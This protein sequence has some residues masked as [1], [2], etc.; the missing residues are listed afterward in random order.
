MYL[1]LGPSDQAL[2]GV[3]VLPGRGLLTL[4]RELRQCVCALSSACYYCC[5]TKTRRWKSSSRKY[6]VRRYRPQQLLLYMGQQSLVGRVRSGTRELG[7]NPG[8]PLSL[9][10]QRLK[11]R[12]HLSFRSPWRPCVGICR[13]SFGAKR[14]RIVASACRSRYL[15]APQVGKGGGGAWHSKGSDLAK[16]LTLRKALP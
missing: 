11:R 6:N 10:L 9:S 7:S 1:G 14:Q 15:P 16:A 4:R 2:T 13:H 3:F 12:Q 8:L 5:K